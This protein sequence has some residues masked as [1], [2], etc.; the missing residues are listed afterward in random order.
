MFKLFDSHFFKAIGDP[1]DWLV[2]HPAGH[3]SVP[4]PLNEPLPQ[5]AL[6]QLDY[7]SIPFG[8]EFDVGLKTFVVPLIGCF[9]NYLP[10]LLKTGIL[11]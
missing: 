3:K 5:V 10:S 11:R 8:K 4:P 7:S 9:S 1:C 2:R 6:L